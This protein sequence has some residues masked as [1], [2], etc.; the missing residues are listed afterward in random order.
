[1]IPRRLVL[2]LVGVCLSLLLGA[3][4]GEPAT[5]AGAD[6]AT[7]V[8]TASSYFP[9]GYPSGDTLAELASQVATTSS[10]S[11]RISALPATYSQSDNDPGSELLNLVMDG[12]VDV[13]V[14]P[15]RIFDAE[16]VSS[17]DAL[18]A[19]F[20]FTSTEQADS[21]LGDP[22]V[23]EMLS[24]LNAIGVK[25]LALTYDALRNALGYQRPLVSPGDFAGK[26]F[27]FRPNHV[28]RAAMAVLGA[29]EYEDVGAAF[30]RAIAD[31]SVV[32]LEDS[33][34][35]PNRQ[36]VGWSVGNEFLSFKANVIVVNAQVWGGLDDSQRES[37]QSAADATREWSRSSMSWHLDLAAA[38]SKFCDSGAGDV[39]L[40]S[41]TDV[42]AMRAAVAPVI[43][44]L[45]SDPLTASVLDRIDQIEGE[46]S[47]T[48]AKPCQA[49]PSPQ[50]GWRPVAPAGDQHVV[51]G[52]WRVDVRAAR[53][54]DAGVG[55]SDAS[56]NE[57]VWTVTI[58]GSEVRARSVKGDDCAAA[59]TLRG[60]RL[61]I[62]WDEATGCGGDFTVRFR[63]DRDVLHLDQAT[64]VEP[65][66]AAFYDAFFA[67]GLTR[68]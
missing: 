43:E 59:M 58:D 60:D 5:R 51:D 37:M 45:R 46:V 24:P 47:A 1:V 48:V 35:Q 21:L 7:R 56:N 3:C 22:I 2:V 10:G 38:A 65:G 42:A 41:E 33:L 54:L 13:A 50:S 61:S 30:E 64:G 36:G 67:P 66:G 9:S 57:S 27:A 20:V 17:L 53:L 25:G 62:V 8:L 11:I 15:A 28:T 44:E 52:V 19:P 40:G 16:G 32:G 34:N 26:A 23:G 29:S 4:D 31:R 14:V 39:V 49:G 18:Q 63:V 55:P 12:A 68:V 6:S